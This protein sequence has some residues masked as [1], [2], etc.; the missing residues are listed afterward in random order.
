MRNDNRSDRIDTTNLGRFVVAHLYEWQDG[1]KEVLFL[2]RTDE[3]ER[4]YQFY[5]KFGENLV[6]GRDQWLAHW[7][8]HR[9]PE[10]MLAVAEQF[11]PV[12]PLEP[13]TDFALA[14]YDSTK[15]PE[16]HPVRNLSPGDR[17]FTSND[18]LLASSVD[19]ATV[20]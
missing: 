6:E 8:R 18:W 13:D 15:H 11:Q 5:D 19:Q 12:R 10:S 20:H 17:S 9:G 16:D 7:L 4:A 14:V 2:F 1:Y 3:E